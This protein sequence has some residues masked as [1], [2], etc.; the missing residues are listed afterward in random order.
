MTIEIHIQPAGA[1]DI[2]HVIVY[3]RASNVSGAA[4]AL[5]T[6]DV[7]RAHL[8]ALAALERNRRL[9]RVE[10]RRILES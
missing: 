4:L 9:A 10:A 8:H 7:G 3:D 5:R 1:P 2:V 6:D